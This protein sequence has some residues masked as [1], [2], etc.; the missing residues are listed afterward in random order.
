MKSPR[1]STVKSPR[2][3]RQN[4]FAKVVA[5]VVLAIFVVTSVGIILIVR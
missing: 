3:R 5:W 2:R 1:P 4:V